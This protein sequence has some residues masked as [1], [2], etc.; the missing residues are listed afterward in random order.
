MNLI[1]F[2]TSAIRLTILDCE[3]TLPATKKECASGSAAP[4][5]TGEDTKVRAMFDEKLLDSMNFS[6]LNQ[7]LDYVLER[8][9]KIEDGLSEGEYDSL[10]DMLCVIAKHTESA[11]FSPNMSES[12]VIFHN[13]R[14]GNRANC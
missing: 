8:I 10:L 2:S 5:S 4:S 6:E 1:V 9:E 3:H 12:A 11:I 14:K 7:S 13:H